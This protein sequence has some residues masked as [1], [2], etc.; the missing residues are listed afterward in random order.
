MRP[1]SPAVS[2]RYGRL[3]RPPPRRRPAA[4]HR[5]PAGLGRWPPGWRAT[6]EP[7]RRWPWVVAPPPPDDGDTTRGVAQVALTGGS[8]G[9]AIFAS[10]L[11]TSGRSDV[12]W[13]RVYV[14]WGDERYLPAGDTN[15]NDTQNDEAGLSQLGLDGGKV[16]RVEGPDASASAEASALSYANTVRG[17]G[18]GEFDVVL[19]GVG[20]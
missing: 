17:F 11:Q 15:R 8:M 4:R 1:R 20:P 10:L 3:V 12:D 2:R 18:R 9:S 13:S 5:R 19:L 6:R 7:R 16:F 14:W